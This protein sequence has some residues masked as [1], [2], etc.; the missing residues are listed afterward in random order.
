MSKSMGD[1]AKRATPAAARK[2]ANPVKHQGH[3]THDKSKIQSRTMSMEDENIEL[4]NMLAV[5]PRVDK[6]TRSDVIFQRPE[7]S[8]QRLKRPLS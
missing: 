4:I 6:S 3:P 1:L 7:K 8:M 5:I 2:P